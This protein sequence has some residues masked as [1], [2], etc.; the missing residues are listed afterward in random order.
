MISTITA[1]FDTTAGQLGGAAVLATVLG[2]ILGKAA[3]SAAYK[4]ARATVGRV[5][6]RAGEAVSAI[7]KSKLGSLSTPLEDVATDFVAFP[8]EQFFV[9]LRKDNAGKLEK[10]LDRLEDVGS[11][12]RANGIAEKLKALGAPPRPLEDATDAGIAFRAAFTANESINEKL[13]G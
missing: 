9:G 10:Q 7:G 13:G 5:A 2:W 1:F 8:V 6:S 3:G 12:T 4:A 11:Q